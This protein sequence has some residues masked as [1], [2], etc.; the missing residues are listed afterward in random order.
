MCSSDI[1]DPDR[2]KPL[3]H[4]GSQAHDPAG[5]MKMIGQVAIVAQ[6]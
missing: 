3:E 1:Q 4:E 2:Q 5:I 6:I